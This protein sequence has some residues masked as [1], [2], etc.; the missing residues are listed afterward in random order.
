[1][2]VDDSVVASLWYDF[3]C[4]FLVSIGNIINIS[5]PLWFC[6]ILHAYKWHCRLKLLS[7]VCSGKATCSSLSLHSTST[8][9]RYLQLF[10]CAIATTASGHQHV[11]QEYVGQELL[12]YSAIHWHAGYATSAL[13]A[14]LAIVLWRSIS[15]SIVSNS[16]HLRVCKALWP[17]WALQQSNWVHNTHQVYPDGVG[18]LQLITHGCFM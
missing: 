5:S 11:G 6:H 13:T 1:M 4:M 14:A 3:A 17:A 12:V 10:K 2:L 8:K 15:M 7:W 9:W 18:A 16:D